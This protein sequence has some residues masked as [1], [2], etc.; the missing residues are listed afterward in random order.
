MRTCTPDAAGRES[1]NFANPAFD[2]ER[3]AIGGYREYLSAADQEI[4]TDI[5]QAVADAMRA[6]RGQAYKP[7]QAVGLYP[8]C[9]TSD[10]YCFARH[11]V[12]PGRTKTFSYTLEFN[13][14]P[15]DKTFLATSNPRTLDTTIR[16]VVPGLIALCLATPAAAAASVASDL[17]PAATAP[18][19][20][21]AYRTSLATDVA[22][23]LTAY[24]A[25]A[26]LGGPAGK[27]AR[28][29]ILTGIR[30]AATRAAKAR[31]R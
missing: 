9:G 4:A 14:G 18:G 17:S 12:D 20:A 26:A 2:G 24:E 16:D 22:R 23:L 31:P 11:I 28:R 21:E 1:R 10:D 8:T 6:V 5:A 29:G 30:Q 13:F 7:L 3:G 27:A 19:R 25:V 15:G